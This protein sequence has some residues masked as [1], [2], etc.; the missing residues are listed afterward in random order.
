[1]RLTLNDISLKFNLDVRFETFL[2]KVSLKIKAYQLFIIYI[3][4]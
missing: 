4:G 2:K 1:M 3:E